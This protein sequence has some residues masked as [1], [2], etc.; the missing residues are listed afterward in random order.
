MEMNVWNRISDSLPAIGEQVLT[1]DVDG[2]YRVGTFKKL[3]S[4]PPYFHCGEEVYELNE[5]THWKRFKRIEEDM[6]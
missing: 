3:P 1:R 2:Y 5:V 4:F 6:K